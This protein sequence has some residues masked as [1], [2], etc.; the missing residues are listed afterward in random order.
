MNSARDLLAEL[1]SLG[2][3]LAVSEDGRLRVSATRGQLSP[4]IKDTIAA[5]KAALVDLLMHGSPAIVSA[6]PRLSQDG[7][8]PLSFFQERLWV[9][10]R[11]DPT[12]T[13]Y[14]IVTVVTS[15]QPVA[16][17]QVSDGLREILRRH[18]VLRSV[19]TD[20]NG[21]PQA[22]AVDPAM[23]P[24]QIVEWSERLESEGQKAIEQA[25]RQAFDLS[26]DLPIRFSLCQLP[27]GRV[28]ILV[29]A[30][31]IAVDAWSM[32]VLKREIDAVFAGRLAELPEPAVQYA[33]YAAWQRASFDERTISAPLDWWAERLKGAPPVSTFPPDLTGRNQALGLTREFMLSA[34]VSSGVRA[35]AREEG[36][37][38]YMT[39]VAA[40]AAA[41]HFHTGQGDLVLGSPMGFRERPE[42]ESVIGPF[43][44]LLALRIDISDDPTFVDLLA[45]ARM[46][47]LD[48]HEHRDVPFEKL[49]E[50]INPVRSLDHGPLIQVAIVQ[51]TA[52][53]GETLR[54][55]SGGAIFDVMWV[56]RDHDG[57]L[58]G[59]LEF[60][61]DRYSEAAIASIAAR[62]EAILTAA[63]THR[64][65]RLSAMPFLLERE[66]QQV[67][68]TF[69]DTERPRPHESF[70]SRFA[71]Q[72]AAT[73]D[74]TAI[75]CA[76]ESLSYE[77]LNRRANQL[78]RYLSGCGIGPGGFVGVHVPRTLD[79]V[80]A[81]IAVHKSGA[82]YVPLDPDFPV[83]R[84][85]YMLADS[86]ARALMSRGP[87]PA[88]LA[89]GAEV[90]HIDL[91]ALGSEVDALPDSDVAIGAGPADIAYMIY[92][93]GS[94]GRPKGVR[95]RQG[96]VSNFLLSMQREPG[97]TATDVLAA[98]TTLSFDIAVL[99][100]C[101]PLVVGARIEL[102]PK[103]TASNGAA[104]TRLL[105]EARVTVM[106]ATPSTWRL[107]L[108]SDWHP[109]AGFRALCG[110][111]PL[112]H[113]VA[114]RLLDKVTELWNLYGPTE[115]TIW[116]TVEH[117]T[118]SVP[119][120]IGHPIDNTRVYVRNAQGQLLPAG[121][122][123]EIFIAGDGVAEG[124]HQR[125]ELTADRFLPDPYRPGGRMY[126][127]GDVGRWSNDG[128]LEHL[129]RT[130]HQVKVRGFRIE[131]GEIESTLVA[132]PAI[133]RAIVLTR[134][135]G[136]GDVRLV[137]YLIFEPDEDLTVSDVRRHLRQTLPDYMIPAVV[138]RIDEAPL[139]PNGKLD[140]AAL[141]DPFA[142]ATHARADY[143]APAPGME[144]T[145]ATIW[146]NLLKVPRVSAEDNFFE[147]GGHSLLA[148]RVATEVQAQIGWRMDPRML[149]FQNL[150]QIAAAAINAQPQ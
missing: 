106:Q 20:V 35:L 14:N 131:L 26:H 21:V 33:D 12:N 130:D 95:V 128:R 80:V 111:E 6:I 9:L 137:A 24:V 112:P 114:E 86:G 83:E 122:A 59:G 141:P 135:A 147:L 129:G 113:E 37:T 64:H 117:V 150:R 84:L 43:V 39:L 10:H 124:Y 51:H 41:L 4:E 63:V 38:V 82:A 60:R 91:T 66:R 22:K 125:D 93:S 2:V 32:Q 140:R 97:L 133:R 62:F 90:R 110:G 74:L 134:D 68:T 23:V 119:I 77:A 7:D 49:V 103:T 89:V 13:A 98:V 126:R 56:V 61:A 104:L 118:K 101:L 92:T 88:A 102:V 109:P 8:V 76:G 54:L 94:T 85:S 81:L 30:H 1:T 52:N 44:N 115:T 15:P 3:R 40:C 123:G 36:V 136:V 27:D 58:Q 47:V 25:T 120:T 138:V 116:S 67:L 34:E 57:K 127:T 148:L 73:P 65:E 53:A 96:G 69:N 31:H 149:F 70:A 79:L 29:I 143:V 78:A 71:R 108:E 45:R 75:V 55:D 132:H 87:V 46:S 28:V 19:V 18:A 121:I 142:G 72:A 99:E 16:M 107:L 50:R 11:L 145:L 146:R 48:A 100:L 17:Q 139:L 5:N 144:L 105:N 42:L